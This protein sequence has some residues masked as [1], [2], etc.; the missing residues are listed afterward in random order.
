MP[1]NRA[2][3]VSGSESTEGQ[4]QL[5]VFIAQ[6]SSYLLPAPVSGGRG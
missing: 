2:A 6:G 3:A 5:R 4:Q 1:P